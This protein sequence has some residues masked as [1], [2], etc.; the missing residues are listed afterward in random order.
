[1]NATSRHRI[2]LDVWDVLAITVYVAVLC[3]DLAA[4]L[5]TSEYG[6]HEQN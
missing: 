5:T 2:H 4:C 1:M 3:F 6:R